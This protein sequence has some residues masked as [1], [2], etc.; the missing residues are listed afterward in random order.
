MLLVYLFF[1]MTNQLLLSLHGLD[2]QSSQQAVVTNPAS[3]CFVKTSHRMK[4]R[5][6]KRLE[7][8]RKSNTYHQSFN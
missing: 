6:T 3:L 4:Q 5:G 8:R 1:S 7:L 2:I